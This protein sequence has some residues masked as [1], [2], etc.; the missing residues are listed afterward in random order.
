MLNACWANL[1]GVTA[2]NTEFIND[3]F[4]GAI[5]TGGQWSES[6]LEGSDFLKADLTD[7][8]FN[9]VNLLCY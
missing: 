4:I 1:E 3:S 5:L 2:L 8:V 7:S 9:N 6:N